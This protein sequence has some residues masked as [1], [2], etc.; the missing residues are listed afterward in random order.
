MEIYG[1]ID[2][3]YPRCVSELPEFGK[4]SP[5]AFLFLEFSQRLCSNVFQ[6]S[7]SYI[8]YSTAVRHRIVNVLVIGHCSV[9]RFG[10]HRFRGICPSFLKNY[11]IR[12]PASKPISNNIEHEEQELPNWKTFSPCMCFFTC[13][14]VPSITLLVPRNVRAAPWYQELLRI[15]HCSGK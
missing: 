8:M 12:V 4:S 14:L 5:F 3:Y 11:T 15:I 1:F 10:L 7:N 13:A 2:A 9:I 6:I